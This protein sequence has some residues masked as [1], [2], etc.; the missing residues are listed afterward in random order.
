MNEPE[1]EKS[2]FLRT[3]RAEVIDIRNIMR[4]HLFLDALNRIENV[5]P[6]DVAV[7]YWAAWKSCHERGWGNLLP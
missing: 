6:R 1:A 2:I 4:S 7:G 3:A 5:G